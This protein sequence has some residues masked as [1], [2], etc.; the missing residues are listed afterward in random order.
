MPVAPSAMLFIAFIHMVLAF[1]VLFRAKKSLARMFFFLAIFFTAAWC[2]SIFFFLIAKT[3][4]SALFWGRIL[5][6][7]GALIP[8]AINS[9]C[10]RAAEARGFAEQEVTIGPVE[11]R[12]GAEGYGPSIYLQDPEGNTVELKGPPEA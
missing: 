9:T 12:Y 8:L 5:F 1:V 3:V 7:S 4:V 11:R 6:S 10:T 2:S